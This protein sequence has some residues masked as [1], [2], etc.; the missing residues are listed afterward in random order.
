MELDTKIISLDTETTGVDFAHGAKPYLV[1]LCSENSK[2]QLENTWYE[3]DVDPFTREPIVNEEDVEEISLIV[4]GCKEIVLQNSKFDVQALH[5][6]DSWCL[7][8]WPWEKTYDTLLAAHLLDSSQKHDLTTLSLIYLNLNVEPYEDSIKNATKKARTIAK[9]KCKDWLIANEGLSCMP[10]AKVA[11]ENDD[12]PW[13][14]DMWLPRAFCRLRPELLP[15]YPGWTLGDAPELHRWYSACSEYSNPDSITTLAL[16]SKFDK[17]IEEKNLGAILAERFKI[18]PIVYQMQNRGITLSEER[19]DDLHKSYSEERKASDNKCHSLAKMFDYKLEL[20]RGAAANNLTKFFCFGRSREDWKDHIPNRKAFRN[21]QTNEDWIAIGKHWESKG[22]TAKATACKEFMGRGQFEVKWLDLPII[23]KTKKT[24]SPSL[25]KA[26]KAEYLH[27][28]PQR[29][30]QKSFIKN[31]NAR[32]KLSTALSYLESYKKFAIKRDCY[33]QLFSSLNPTGTHTLRWSSKNPNQQQVSSQTIGELERS[34]RYVFGPAP[35]RE[36]WSLDYDNLELRIPAYECKEPAM[37]ELFENPNKAPFFGSYHLLIVSILHKKEWKECL[38]EVGE[39]EA[40]NLF[41][42]K[43]KSTLYA[44]TKNGNFAELYGAVDKSDGL[45]TADVAFH[46][47]GAQS[48]ISERLTKKTRLN[49]KWIN[50][51]EEYGY[52]ETMPDKEIDP[53][54]GYPLF[55]ARTRWGKV[56]PTIPLNYHVQGT[57]CWIIMRAMIKLQEFININCPDSFMTM[58][59]HDE[60]VFDMPKIEGKGNQILVDKFRD[61]MESIG[62]DIGVTLTCGI[63]YHSTSWSQVN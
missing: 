2:G 41:K 18:L 14:F 21:P 57:A 33:S 1:T 30:I 31:L 6:L 55:C 50:Y 62:E 12:K 17:I 45:G 13:K 11:S 60:V 36:W 34:C 23:S 29:S 43:Y 10:S 63:D 3:W 8:S 22:D 59:V 20:P 5:T 47:K 53:K 54:K 46:L 4:D 51:A 40:A 38:E 19:L 16:K 37:L 61:I 26:A 48:I 56:K 7:G 24:G 58:Q 39:L 44:W 25:N 15:I 35:G 28:L 32:G 9:S 52:I 42:K 49:K 27:I